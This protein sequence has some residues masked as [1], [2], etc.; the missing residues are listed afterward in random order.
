[1]KLVHPQSQRGSPDHVAARA[2]C[3]ASPAR[4]AVEHLGRPKLN[5][6][7]LPFSD[8]V[9]VGRHAL[10]VG[11]AR[12]GADGKLPEGIEAQTKQALDNVG[13]ILKTRGAWL[14]GRVSLHGDAER[15]GG[16][17]GDQQ[18]LCDLFPRRQAAGPQRLRRKRA[19]ARRIDR[20]RMPGLRRARNS[21]LSNSADTTAHLA[22]VTRKILA[23]V[24][25]RYLSMVRHIL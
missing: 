21:R 20:A 23:L 25:G 12:I 3:A 8:A 18:S 7:P 24:G 6:Q 11:P 16:L 19:R 9:R 1:M 10:S 4:P 22:R 13:A 15:H 2:E 17:A 5:G 14:R